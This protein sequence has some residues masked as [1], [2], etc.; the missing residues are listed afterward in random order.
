MKKFICMIGCACILGFA[1]LTACAP[2]E[3]PA[4]SPVPSPNQTRIVRERMAPSPTPSPFPSPAAPGAGENTASRAN[5]IANEVA[6]MKEV[7]T[8]TVVITGNT[9]MVGVQFDKQYK[10]KMTTKLKE[11]IDNRVKKVDND[12][13]NVAVTAEPDLFSRIKT[14]ASD[15]EG[16][17]PLTGFVQEIQEIL[18]RINPR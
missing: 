7:D 18:N 13:D 11:M 16:G 8:A 17:K 15:I 10:G 4:P 6:K 2:A 1:F 14:L 12:I 9:A 5:K 3:R